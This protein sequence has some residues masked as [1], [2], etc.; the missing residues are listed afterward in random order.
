M[1]NRFLTK[2][3]FCHKYQVG[4]EDGETGGSSDSSE[5]EERARGKTNLAYETN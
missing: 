1:V 2:F 5:M 3:N 4:R